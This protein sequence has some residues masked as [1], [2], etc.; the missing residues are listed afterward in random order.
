MTP[1]S[2]PV[3][4]HSGDDREYPPGF[5]A[6]RIGNADASVLSDIGALVGGYR[7]PPWYQSKR[8]FAVLA[9]AVI[10]ALAVWGIVGVLRSPAEDG[11]DSPAEPAPTGETVPATAPVEV[12]RGDPI[13]AVPPPP[14]APPTA[15]RL[16]PPAGRSG[17]WP[18]PRP[19]RPDAKPEIGVT[20]TPA[21][22]API[23]VAPTPRQAPGS[24][25]SKPGDAPKGGGWPW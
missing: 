5:R 13:E 1:R 9:V 21:T 24:D 25:S 22:R 7:S 6:A 14:P 3:D 17:Q 4:D 20:R 19:S 15:E 18:R 23:S 10:V 8:A 2:L 16:D 11:S 12:S